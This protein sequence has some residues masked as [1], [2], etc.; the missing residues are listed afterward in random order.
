MSPY[1]FAGTDVVAALPK[2]L[3]TQSAKLTGCKPAAAF[4]KQP[5]WR[6]GAPW[7]LPRECSNE[8]RRLRVHRRPGL[9]ATIPVVSWPGS[10]LGGNSRKFRPSGTQQLFSPFAFQTGPQ[11]SGS[12]L[13][14]GKRV[15]R[16]NRDK[17]RHIER[18]Y[19]EGKRRAH[20]ASGFEFRIVYRM[21][22]SVIVSSKSVTGRRHSILV[23][24]NRPIS[25]TGRASFD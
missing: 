19:S 8:Y 18:H 5:A 1:S 25:K 20:Y 3:S 14:S 13:R 23:P 2:T 16:A 10:D 11:A 22:L 15:F 12:K 24:E 7:G 21:K 4:Q 6:N 9:I 17:T